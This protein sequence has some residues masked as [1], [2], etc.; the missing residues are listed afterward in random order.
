MNIEKSTPKPITILLADDS[1]DDRLM[2]REALKESFVL[3]ALR[4][5][6]DGEELMD[7]LHRRGR[8]VL[9]EDSPRPGLILLDINMPRKDGYEA[10]QE[11][12]SDPGLRRIPVVILTTSDA[13]RDII[14]SY[15]LG[16][17]SFISKPVTFAGLVE[18]MKAFGKYWIEI[19]TI[20]P[21]LEG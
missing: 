13:E 21:T 11:I 18:V 16:V 8:Y 15:E 2:T 4:E 10:L 19:V 20:P 14:R 5:V 9:P 1:E 3:N 7:Y 12:R 17:S 6:E